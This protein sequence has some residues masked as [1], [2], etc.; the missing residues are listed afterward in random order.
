MLTA[1]TSFA[2]LLCTTLGC[3]PSLA[4]AQG[5]EHPFI[6]SF[7]LTVLDGR[8]QVAWT[9]QGGS[10]CDGSEVLRSTNGVD[11]SVAHRIDGLCGDAA[12]DVPFSWM[13]DAPPEFSTLYY[14]IRLGNEGYSSI[15]SVEFIQLT[16][17]DL[18]F[19]PSP[20][21]GIATLLLNVKASAQ[22]DLL[23]FDAMGH[24]VMEQGGLKGREHEI[25]LPDI[26]AGMYV[27]VASS[28]GKLFRGRFVKE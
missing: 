15:K 11:F 19:F 26:P 25:V 12:L 7:D 23:I 6:K 22:V 1:R 24:V 27:Y 20:T 9:M 4:F 17:S 10:T 3:V 5:E 2:L 28:E 14:R 13:D 8:V 16:E 18:R 21:T